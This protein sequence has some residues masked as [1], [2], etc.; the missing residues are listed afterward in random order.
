MNELEIME[1]KKSEI[2]KYVSSLPDK[3]ITYHEVHAKFPGCADILASMLIDQ[4][5]VIHVTDDELLYRL[6]IISK[7]YVC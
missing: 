1:A 7:E 3:Q 5:L 4:T 6:N 2:L